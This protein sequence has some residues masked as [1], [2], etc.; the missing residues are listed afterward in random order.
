[1]KAL[2]WLAAFLQFLLAWL[3]SQAVQAAPKAHAPSDSEIRQLLVNRID[4]EQQS[5][6]IV[7]GVIG[8]AGRRIV[9]YG[10]LEKGDRRPLNGDTLFEIGSITKVFT[11]LVAADMAQRGEIRLDDP[12]A[13][14]LPPEVKL[15][16]RAGRQITF[17]DLATHTSGL[18]RMPTNFRPKD[19]A[20]PYA[21]YTA[22]QLYEFLSTYELPRDIGVKW[23]YSNLGFGL[24]GHV[25]ALRA[26]MD[27]EKLVVA[28]ICTPLG[29]PS[30]RVT[31]SP[32]LTQRLA[33]GHDA[34]LVTVP[35]WDQA[36]LAGAGALHSSAN[37]LLT[38]LAAVM[39]Y[40]HTPL[41]PAL[42]S[43]LAT[44]RPTGMPFQ[45]VGL[46]WEVDTRGGGKL[47]WK[48][49]GT[50]GYRTFI[51]FSPATR[52]GVVALSNA[53]T[54]P[55]ADDIA[56]HLLD[57]RY[58]LFVPDAP[59]KQA[60][61]E[62]DRL[63]N[64][65][66]R[67]E[68]APN[69]II[70]VSRE[71]NELFAQ[72]T[73]QP[74]LSLYAKSDEEF[75][76][77]DVPNASITFE[78]RPHANA[79]ALVLHQNGRDVRGARIDAASAQALEDAVAKRFREQTAQPGGEAFLRRHI[80]E[81]QHNQVSYDEFAPELAAA[82][83][84]RLPHTEA[85]IATLGALQ[86]IT[87]KGVGPGGADIYQVTFANGVLEWRQL[88]GADGKAALSSVRKLP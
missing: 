27:Y 4:V 51:G 54:G 14:Y 35:G 68:L 47:I 42:L 45:E 59:P 30:T 48:N 20:N 9:S 87:F 23:E 72:G 32:E 46:A 57:A 17:I 37:D 56:M 60:A 64:Y 71:G 55:G 3:P 80:E 62:T 12:I 70:T 15:P 66:G 58:P 16:T 43:M 69:F 41:Q 49:G 82:V 11:A 8:P 6:G 52:I 50:G 76:S 22:E 63:D 2:V 33:A 53:A 79:T 78:G 65:A 81:L 61:V 67:Y 83:R 77:K 39:G 74:R 25:L 38:F 85:F 24:L 75:L 29:M 7:V 40:T 84:E 36:V 1:M 73:G 31:L 18:P 13:K 88:L 28:R 44:T 21:D 86:S 34:G 26:G 5:V 10:S 19:P